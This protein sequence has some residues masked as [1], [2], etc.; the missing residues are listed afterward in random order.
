MSGAGPEPTDLRWTVLHR[1]AFHTWFALDPLIGAVGSV[2]EWI[3]GCELLGPPREALVVDDG[4][5]CT[6]LI[7]G[8]SVA[9]EFVVVAYERL[10]IVRSF[11]QT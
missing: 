5:R 10:I 11:E 3:R 2:T 9:V 7:P 6:V 8:S 1:D 4:E